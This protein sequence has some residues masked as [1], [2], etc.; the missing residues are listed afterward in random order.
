[1]FATVWPANGAMLKK[2]LQAFRTSIC[3][4]CMHCIAFLLPY[5]VLNYQLIIR[6]LRMGLQDPYQHNNGSPYP[7]GVIIKLAQDLCTKHAPI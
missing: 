4:L 1:M 7:N 5:L 3:P 2:I 6:F